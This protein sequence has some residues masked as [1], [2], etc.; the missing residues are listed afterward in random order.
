[1]VVKM[2]DREI[3]DDDAERRN[4]D[5]GKREDGNACGCKSK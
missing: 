5:D 3:D 1:M 4:C 2:V